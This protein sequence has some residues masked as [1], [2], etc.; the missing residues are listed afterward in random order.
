MNR[1]HLT[2][3]TVVLAAMVFTACN[4]MSPPISDDAEGWD[5]ET[6]EDVNSVLPDLEA[7]DGVIELSEDVVVPVTTLVNGQSDEPTDDASATEGPVTD[8]VPEVPA[9]G[10][11]FPGDVAPGFVRFGAAIDGNGDPIARHESVVNAPIG[12]RRTFWRWD[13]RTTSMIRTAN[14]DLAA[15]RLPWVSVKTPGW[16]AMASG[17]LDSE[18][19]D[20]LRALSGV[21]GPVWLTVHHEPEGGGGQPG[22][23]DPAGAPAWRA[24]QRRV[25]QR[26]DALGVR[27]VAFAPILMSWTFDPRSNR[28]PD[29]WWV[30]G[31]WDFAGLD[32]YVDKESDTTF[33][34]TMWKNARA[35]YTAK[36]LKIAIGEWGNRGTD[37]QAAQEVEDFYNSIISSGFSDQAQVIG[38]SAFDSNLNSPRGGW[39]L[40][41]AQLSKFRDLMTR[42]TS[43]TVRQDGF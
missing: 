20:M 34:L 43:L 2:I 39:E 23:D 3:S 5:T 27:N 22:P 8:P 35:F 30:D 36:G 29:E 6:L 13:Q 7:D 17:S 10:P 24:M 32:H 14:S 9:L 1:S 38:M 19:D 33:Q 18:I 40:K 15:G 12:I 21:D 25:R 26:I 42:G 41:G 37:G 16:A 4:P 11:A 28:N 31:I